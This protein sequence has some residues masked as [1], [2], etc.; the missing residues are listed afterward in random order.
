MYMNNTK[1]IINIV[2]KPDVKALRLDKLF[3]S[4]KSKKKI[5]SIEL[6]INS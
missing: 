2:K 4:K 5:N 1:Y 3:V 6:Y